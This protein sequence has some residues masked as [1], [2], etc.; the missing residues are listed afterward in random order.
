[1]EG[2]RTGASGQEGRW[3]RAAAAPGH[4]SE[5]GGGG[6]N[7]Q[8]A[9]YSTA[10]STSEGGCRHAPEAMNPGAMELQ[11]MP[12]PEYSRAT[13]LDMAITPARVGLGG[14]KRGEGQGVET[15]TTWRAHRKPT[16]DSWQGTCAE[17]CWSHQVTAVSRPSSSP[18]SPR[19]PPGHPPRTHAPPLAAE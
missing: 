1:M 5:T 3:G 11:V 12:R 6:S 8:H 13:D 2:S 7:P 4:I 19:G 16:V 14:A 10:L 17:T 9:Q 15:M 18:L